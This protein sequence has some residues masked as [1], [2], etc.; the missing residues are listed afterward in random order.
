MEMNR[1]SGFMFT[2]KDYSKKG[3]MSTI[4]GIISAVSIC[5][6]LYLTYMNQGQAE[7]RYGTVAFLTL[8]FAGVGMG[9]G[10][11]SRM[12]KDKFYLF[13]YIGIVMNALSLMAI[14]FI[15][16]AGAYGL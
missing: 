10:I 13:S 1:R 4:L 6:A 7:F 2:N 16:Y 14:S 5:L 8:I 15:L 12:E 3:I 11:A 9:L